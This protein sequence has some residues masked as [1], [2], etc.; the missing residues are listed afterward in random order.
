MNKKIFKII[1]TKLT[2]F[3]VKIN[4]KI[5]NNIFQKINT[6]FFSISDI[7]SLLNI[8]CNKGHTYDVKRLIKKDVYIVIPV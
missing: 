1:L 8:V 2:I 3:N 4:T 7:Y 6:K 5:F